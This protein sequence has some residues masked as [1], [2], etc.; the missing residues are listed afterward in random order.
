MLKDCISFFDLDV[1]ISLNVYNPHGSGCTL[2]LEIISP[3]KAILV[4]L[5]W[6]EKFHI[7]FSAY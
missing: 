2:Y 3:K 4:H 7:F 1:G 6:P 5:K